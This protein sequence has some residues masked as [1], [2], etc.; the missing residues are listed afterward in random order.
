MVSYEPGTPVAQMT[1]GS[2]SVHV[3]LESRCKATWKRGFKL[4]WREAGPPNHRDHK[5]DADHKVVDKELSLWTRRY[6]L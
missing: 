3:D 6:Q 5:V 4:S 2:S 1:Q